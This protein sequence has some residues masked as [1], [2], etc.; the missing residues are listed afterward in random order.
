MHAILLDLI[1]FKLSILSSQ[2]VLPALSIIAIS[3]VVSLVLGKLFIGA[4]RRFFR[5]RVREYTPESHQAKNNTPTMGGIFLLAA[6]ILTSGFFLGVYNAIFWVITVTILGFAAIGFLDD[7]QKIRRKKGISAKSKFVLQWLIAA[8]VALLLVFWLKVPTTVTLPLINATFN[9]GYLYI[10]WAMFILVSCSNAVNL[11]DG[12]DGLACGVLL[13][14][15]ALFSTIAYLSSSISSG[16][17]GCALIGATAGFL[18]FNKYPALIFMGDVGALSLGAVY[19][20]L[21]LITKQELLIPLAGGIF[22]AEELSVMLQ[23]FSYKY[24]KK[25]IF[26]MAPLHHHFELVGWSEQKITRVF[27]LISTLLCFIALLIFLAQ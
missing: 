17:Y 27:T 8:V 19:A 22:F 18:Y 24:F 3:C 10:F 16:S 1:K 15:F 11:T 9:L 2:W 21:A 23:V 25:R 6:A 4:S 26:K 12:L 7:W 5:S 20:L 14:N 13:P